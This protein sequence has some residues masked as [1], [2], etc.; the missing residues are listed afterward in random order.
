MNLDSKP[1]DKIEESD[2]QVLIDNKISEH[3]RIEYKS[4]LPGNS[5]EDRKEFLADVSSFANTAGGYL[6]Y[7]IV[8]NDGIP[9]DLCGVELDSVDRL[10]LTWQSRLRDCVEPQIPGIDIQPIEL[11]SG[12]WVIILRIPR[13]WLAP[14]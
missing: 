3:K 10:K 6:I 9:V 2:L 13:S 1:L 7:G 14:H 12:N 8:A 5:N 11:S 4:A